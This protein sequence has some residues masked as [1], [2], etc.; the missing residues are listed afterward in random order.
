V[1][2]MP[3]VARYRATEPRVPQRQETLL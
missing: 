3:A 1:R 2:P